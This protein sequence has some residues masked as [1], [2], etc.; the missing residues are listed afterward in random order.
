[1]PRLRVKIRPPPPPPPPPRISRRM[2]AAFV[3][4]LAS[5]TA[6]CATLFGDPLKT[7]AMASEPSEAEVWVNGLLLGTTPISLDLAN[8]ENHAVVFRK[9]GHRSVTCLLHAKV[10]AGWVVLDVL[11]GVIPVIVDAATGA[12]KGIEQDA[13]NVVLPVVGSGGWLGEGHAPDRALEAA[14]QAGWTIF[15]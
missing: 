2:K 3:V 7:V 9:V 6:G 11:A 8:T 14:R 10:G 13:C 1:M 12:W 4:A 15:E 5:L